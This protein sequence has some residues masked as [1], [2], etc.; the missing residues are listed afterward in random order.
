VKNSE[1][2]QEFAIKRISKVFERRI[3]AKRTLREL[4]LLKHFGGHENVNIEHPIHKDYFNSRCH[5][6]KEPRNL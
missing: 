2:G 4:K 1:T 5:A 3:I 6:S